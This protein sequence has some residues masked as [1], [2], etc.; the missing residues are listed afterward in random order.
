[1]KPALRIYLKPISISELPLLIRI[2]PICILSMV[3]PLQWYFEAEES[4]TLLPV[5]ITST[6]SPTYNHVHSY[7]DDSTLHS[8]IHYTSRLQ[9]IK[10]DV[11]CWSM[12]NSLFLDMKKK[13]DS[14]NSNL[15]AHKASYTQALSL[16]QFSDTQCADMDDHCLL[17]TAWNKLFFFLGSLAVKQ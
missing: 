3:I 12:S 8:S 6:L 2:I 11:N 14:G 17:N 5:Y 4:P 15:P 9:I 10:L 13:L 16:R 1:M 7:A